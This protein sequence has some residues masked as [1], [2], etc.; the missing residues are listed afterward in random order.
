MPTYTQNEL[1]DVCQGASYVAVDST[2]TYYNFG[3]FENYNGLD[4]QEYMKII[5]SY[6]G[7]SSIDY[8]DTVPGTDPEDP[9]DYK[10]YPN[11]NISGGTVIIDDTMN[12]DDVN[13]NMLTD[14]DGEHVSGT[15][16][17]I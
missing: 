16:N 8:W 2:T 13:G 12:E 6:S 3:V 14:Q 7:N 17:G 4:I 9:I 5:R 1:V 11:Y 10:E 15:L